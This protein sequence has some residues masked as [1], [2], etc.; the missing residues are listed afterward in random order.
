MSVDGGAVGG[1]QANGTVANV[2]N[3]NFKVQIPSFDPL[4][5]KEPGWVNAQAWVRSIDR[6]IRAAG[7]NADGEDIW[8]D[9]MAAAI[10]I[11]HLRGVAQDWIEK[12]EKQEEGGTDVQALHSWKA[13]KIAFSKRY[14]K[15]LTLS[16][17]VAKLRGL[18]QMPKESVMD[19]QDRVENQTFDLFES[20][21]QKADPY[22]DADKKAKEKGRATISGLLF[23][24]GLHD[25]IREQAC[26]SAPN[27]T[28]NE[29]FLEIA[30]RIEQAELDKKQRHKKNTE[31]NVV[32]QDSESS[33]AEVDAVDM[34]KKKKTQWKGK[35]QDKTRKPDHR[36]YECYS[37][38]KI[39]HIAEN[40]FKKQG[41][42]A[43]QKQKQRREKEVS[44][45][46]GEAQCDSVDFDLIEYLQS[47]GN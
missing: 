27:G 13:L 2:A 30:R 17:Q 12:L 22:N 16:E 14:F 10:A 34:K 39:G 47:L 29:D 4:K 44:E 21:W 35:T 25:N 19:F 8:E 33:E 11:S 37:C 26:I 46:T 41:M 42:L 5:A 20:A 24:A 23:A 31:V 28:S 45:A 15:M 6:A 40:C 32:S 7:K 43:G 9:S 36:N 18:N 38:H 3:T 1:Q